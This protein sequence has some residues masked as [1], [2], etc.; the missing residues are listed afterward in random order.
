MLFYV[1]HLA[2]RL[3]G[4]GDPGAS[5]SPTT[6]TRRSLLTPTGDAPSTHD[7][8][9][10]LIVVHLMDASRSHWRFRGGLWAGVGTEQGS[11]TAFIQKGPQGANA[12]LGAPAS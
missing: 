3:T 7:R 2:V 4:A 11:P 8:Q 5:G 6:G 9:L 1:R 10:Q 12:P